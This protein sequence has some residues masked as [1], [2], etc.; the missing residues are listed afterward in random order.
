MQAC[1]EYKIFNNFFSISMDNAFNN[2]A[3]ISVLKN[4]MHPMLEGLI[5][6]IRC[7]C[8]IINLCVKEGFKYIDDIVMVIR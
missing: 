5:F 2:F 1:R 3:F 6:H 4:H 8:H 7:A